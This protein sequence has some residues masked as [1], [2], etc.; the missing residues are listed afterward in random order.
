MG[1][2]PADQKALMGLSEIWGENGL[3]AFVTLQ[4][5]GR[6]ED[7]ARKD[8]K[9]ASCPLLSL[10]QVWVS[11]TPFIPTRHPKVTR[12][13]ARKLDA[14]GLQIGS[15]EHEVRRL[16]CLENLPE[17]TSIEP[18]AYTILGKKQ[19]GW[20]NFR[21]SRGKGLSRRAGS[22][23]YGYRIVFSQPVQGPVAVGYGAHFGMGLFV[24]EDEAGKK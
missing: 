10:S 9:H 1:F 24:P 8:A 22:R 2:E 14:T 18:I 20:S 19:T 23:G 7:F 21:L 17:I 16:L 6:P 5:F 11:A 12:A 15:P 4:G 13:G 3:R